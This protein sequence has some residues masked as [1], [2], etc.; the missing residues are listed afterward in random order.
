MITESGVASIANVARSSAGS[1]SIAQRACGSVTVRSASLYPSCC[2]RTART[3]ATGMPVVIRSTSEEQNHTRARSHSR[4][5]VPCSSP[6]ARWWTIAA[7]RGPFSSTSSVG[8]TNTGGPSGKRTNRVCRRSVNRAGK[9]A[10]GRKPASVTLLTITCSSGRAT[11][12]RTAGHSASAISAREIAPISRVLSTGAPCSS[13]RST[14]V[15]R[16][17]WALR[18]RAWPWGVL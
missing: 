9:L 2:S 6:S 12:S 18:A 1:A 3:C 16:P 11:R 15:N 13:P 10:S 7:R 5:L 17:S 4:N 8:M 14:S